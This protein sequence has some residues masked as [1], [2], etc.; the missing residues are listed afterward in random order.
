MSDSG[1]NYK[2]RVCQYKSH[3]LHTYPVEHEVYGTVYENECEKP[4]GTFTTIDCDPLAIFSPNSFKLW[5]DLSLPDR[6]SLNIL[7]RP[8]NRDDLAIVWDIRFAK[9]LLM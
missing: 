4:D 5:V 8:F 9:P 1:D 7:D 3:I 6:Y 2:M